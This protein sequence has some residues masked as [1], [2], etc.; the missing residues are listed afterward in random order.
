MKRNQ[1]ARLVLLGASLLLAFVAISFRILGTTS[2]PP[3]AIPT[4]AQLPPDVAASSAGDAVEVALLPSGAQSQPAPVGVPVTSSE[5]VVPPAAAQPQLPAAVRGMGQSAMVAEVAQP[6]AASDEAAASTGALPPSA[7]LIEKEGTTVA[8]EAPAAPPA[9]AP[10]IPAQPPALDAALSAPPVWQRSEETVL[11]PDSLVGATPIPETLTAEEEA[12]VQ[13]A[14]AEGLI[15]VIVGIDFNWEPNGELSAQEVDAQV[16]TMRSQRLSIVSRASNLG[17]AAIVSES[18]DWIIPYMALNVDAAGLRALATM[19]GV[20][21]ITENRY[22]EMFLNEGTRIVRAQSMWAAGYEGQG[23]TVAIIDGGTDMQHPALIGRN[24]GEACY[25]GS[26]AGSTSLCYNFTNAQ[27]GLGAASPYRCQQLGASAPDDGCEHGTHV[28]GTAAG[29]DQA[30]GIRGVAP[31]ANVIGVN[32]FSW[33][34]AQQT[35]LASDSNIISGLNYVYSLRFSYNIAAVNLSLGGGQFFGY[36]DTANPAMT[37]IFASLRAAGI[38]PVVATGNNGFNTSIS[39]P[40]CISNAV[41]VGSVNDSR[42]RSVFSN[43]LNTITWFMAPGESIFAAVPFGSDTDIASGGTADGYGTL[44]GTS[45]ATPHVAGAIAVL[46][47]ATGVSTEVALTTLRT[48]GQAIAVPNGTTP[49]IDLWRADRSLRGLSTVPSNDLFGA[50]TVFSTLGYRAVQETTDATGSGTDP[51]LCNTSSRSVWYR[52][53]APATQTIAFDTIGS[54]YDTVMAV[55]TGTEGAL[56]QIVCNDDASGVQSRVQF[57]AVAGTTYHIQVSKFGTGTPL[58]SQVLRF[59]SSYVSGNPNL[60]SNGGFTSGTTGFTFNGFLAATLESGVLN[61]RR[62][63]PLG[64]PYIGYLLGGSLPAATGMDVTLDVGNSSAEAKQFTVAVR[65]NATGQQVA[66]NFVVPANSALAQYRLRGVTPAGWTQ[67]EL[68][69][70]LEDL[71]VPSI[72]FDNISLQLAIGLSLPATECTTPLTADREYAVNGN[73]QYGNFNWNFSGFLAATFD[74]GTLLTRRTA[75]FG[76][77]LVNQPTRLPLPPGAPVQLQVQVGNDSAEA[78]YF[79]LVLGN[80]GGTETLSCPFVIPANSILRT[81]TLQG[82]IP[83]NWTGTDV[84]FFAEDINIPWLRVDNVSLQYVPSLTL[85]NTV[86]SSGFASNRNYI[87]N[88]DFVYGNLFHSFVGP[89][90]ASFSG[91]GALQMTRL[92]STGFAYWEQTTR[93]NALVEEDWQMTV[94]LGNTTTA[95]KSAYFGV[96]DITTSALF[97]ECTF[98]VPANSPLQTYTM[99]FSQSQAF[100]RMSAYVGVADNNQPFLL[101]DNIVLQ[102]TSLG[103]TNVV[104][105]LLPGGAAP[106]L[107]TPPGLPTLP[108]QIPEP[109]VTD[110]PKPPI[111]VPTIEPTG[112]PTIV[113]PTPVTPVMEETP[114]GFEPPVAPTVEAPTLEVPTVEA[115]TAEVPTAEPTPEPPTPEAPVEPAPASPEAPP[116]EGLSPGG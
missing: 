57:N 14:E 73:F 12:L 4:L 7:P 61:T 82:R 74:S 109:F 45:M 21:T 30:A 103:I 46:K 41:S 40:A 108:I 114:R 99:R 110:E 95:A 6:A 35:I 49:L 9:A 38:A 91:G 48:T 24:A 37:S 97:S 90:S 112:E 59:N 106:L 43:S 101:V 62:T 83:S 1:I 5:Q 80:T 64:L 69:L 25:S 34:P 23:Q 88:G 116:A 50:A 10:V 42:V 47:Q 65:D 13:R 52:Y 78:K 54:N 102:Q 89:I 68:R 111:A 22:N 27:I 11:E 56:T 44:S 19:P 79:S 31:R 32:V 72:L 93:I 15:S 29:N 26:V 92:G 18:Q 87:L 98:S 70:F 60:I 28:A 2:Q 94:Q 84:R 100:T 33:V 81:F 3:V 58:G 113:I 75:P 55:Y 8:E 16:A 86:C 63:S 71:N 36:C 53:F 107:P 17:E 115:P 105:C 20:T 76:F 104:Q 39:Y 85:V 77:G 96:Y 51:A 67:P 66:C